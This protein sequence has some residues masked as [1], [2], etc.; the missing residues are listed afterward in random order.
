MHS[1]TTIK[2]LASALGVSPS[3]I[4]KA[5][6]NS[7]EISLKTKERVRETAKAL[8][9]VPN[10]YARSLKSKM[11]KTVGVV[12]PN[13]IDDFFAKV[14][15]GIEKEASEHGFTVQ[16]TF[17]NDQKKSE[18]D[19]LLGLI[20]R[21]VDG[22]L[23]SF[24]K[25]TQKT[26]NYREMRKIMTYN[27]P[28]VMFDRI[29]K[30]IPL[31]SVTIDDFAGAFKATK[32]LSDSGCRRI[33]FLSPLSNTS[34]GRSRKEGYISALRHKKKNGMSPLCIE[35]GN[36]ENFRTLFANS[37]REHTP[38]GILAADEL[39]AIYAL[40]TLQ[41]IGYKVPQDISVIGFTNGP[42]AQSSNPSLSVISQ[43][44]EQIGAKS[45]HL[46]R[47]RLVNPNGKIRNMVIDPG[48]ILRNSTKPLLLD[49]TKTYPPLGK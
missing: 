5:L 29:N 31:D 45:F 39:S 37:M 16:I 28:I 15:H 22:I 30:E 14:L 40:N 8:G 3:T 25:E 11:T 4:S 34:V 38:D 41:Q 1:I 27:K 42:M 21:S 43:H 24:S 6:G 12:V 13:V 47:T 48:L 33:A 35:I 44:A 26:S 18:Y 10:H 46:L 32:Y 9:Y 49:D 36:Y 17:S 19:N 23:I 2:D 7:P 20:N